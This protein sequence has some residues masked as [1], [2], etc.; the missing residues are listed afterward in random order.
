M[1]IREAFIENRGRVV[2]DTCGAGTVQLFGVIH[3]AREYLGHYDDE[4]DALADLHDPCGADIAGLVGNYAEFWIQSDAPGEAEH[5]VLR[6]DD[7]IGYARTRA[8]AAA[9]QPGSSVAGRGENSSGETGPHWE[10]L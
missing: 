8:A 7:V 4:R 10:I 1:A 2:I 9:L 6:G 5:P 3:G